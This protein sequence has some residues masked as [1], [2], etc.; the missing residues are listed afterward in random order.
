VI[1]AL[2]GAVPADPPER[3]RVVAVGATVDEDRRRA[4]AQR[5]TTSGC[6]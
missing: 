1:A 4:P 2:E 6:P 5:N 3:E